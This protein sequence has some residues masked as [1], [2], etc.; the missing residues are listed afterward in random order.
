MSPFIS[1]MATHPYTDPFVADI[2]CSAPAL[3]TG[4]QRIA[5]VGHMTPPRAVMLNK[6]HVS[7]RSLFSLHETLDTTAFYMCFLT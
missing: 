2:F 4:V 5:H 6:S 1:I 7:S 3:G